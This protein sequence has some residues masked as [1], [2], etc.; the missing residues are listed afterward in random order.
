M[1]NLPNKCLVDTN[2]PK[3]ANKVLDPASI[4]DDLTHCVLACIEAV[5]HVITTRSLVMDSGDEI[6]DEYRRHLS[7][8]GQPGVGDRFMKWVH[9]HRWTLPEEDRITITK[10]GNSYDEFP[11]HD[12]LSNFDKS[13]RKFVAVANAHPAKPKIL[14]ATDCKW[15]G[16]SSALEDVGI[17]VQFLCSDY[18]KA[19]YEEKFET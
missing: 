3:T 12:G 16:W 18:V 6:Y 9:D 7:M 11:I 8:S 2:V 1:S 19:K 13:D 14:Q 10:N 15:W 17:S 5:E 4:P